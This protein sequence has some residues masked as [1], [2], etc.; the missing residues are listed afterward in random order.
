MM[1]LLDFDFNIIGITETRIKNDALPAINIDIEGYSFEQTP[2]EASCG[3]A[4]LYIANKFKYK[5]RPDLLIYK[6]KSLE[7][8]FIEVIHQ[9]K[10]NIIVGCIYKHPCMEIDEFISDYMTP[11]L[12]KLSSEN[13][14]IFLMG[15]FNINLLQ[16]N[17]NDHISEYFNILTSNNLLPHITLPTRITD[18]SST[19]IDNIFTNMISSNPTSGNLTL[20]V[21]DHLPQ[22]FIM[23][24][25]NKKSTPIKHNILR[26]NLKNINPQKI[27]NDFSITNWDEIMNIE[28]GDVNFSCESFFSEFNNLLDNHVPL[29][30]ISN[31]VF[32]RQFKPWITK[33]IRVSIKKRNK[34]KSKFIRAKDSNIKKLLEN[35]F[36]FYR[37]SIVTLTRQS[38][39]NHFN[40]FFQTNNKNLR[41]TLK[42]IKSLI[43]IHNKKTSLPTS[44]SHGNTLITDPS[45]ISN[46]F[47]DFFTSIAGN[48]QSSIHSSHTNYTKYLK[49]P[50]LHSIF[51]SP[52]DTHE[53][54]LLIS[55]MNK[56]KATG[57]NSIPTPVLQILNEK[58]STVL[59]KLFNLSFSNGT[60]GISRWR[61]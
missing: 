1:S 2:T 20:S 38:K 35:K 10:P 21:S 33:A 31:K 16:C 52:T 5:T 48:I 60:Q 7:S 42:G 22:F 43:N 9:N 15:D 28:M 17:D 3:G 59:S 34:L 49:S 61:V 8:I 45:E 26:R 51:I 46:T 50:N 47:N 37:N 39:K 4:L 32:K 11:L 30:K 23:P 12:Q 13:K 41:E 18:K 6:S 19:L 25:I 57:P 56:C 29:K 55:K 36:K 53:I 44:I 27:L 58:I 40:T 24:D 14:S 54:S